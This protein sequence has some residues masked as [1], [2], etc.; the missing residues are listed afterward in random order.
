MYVF[1]V[2]CNGNLIFYVT[3]I[4]FTVYKLSVLQSCF[5]MRAFLCLV[6]TDYQFLIMSSIKDLFHVQSHLWLIGE[7]MECKRK[8]NSDVTVILLHLIYYCSI[9]NVRDKN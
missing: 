9:L 8:Y 4:E 7:L 5:V 3:F 2:K 1:M 6:S